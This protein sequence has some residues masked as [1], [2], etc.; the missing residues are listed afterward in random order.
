MLYRR[1]FFMSIVLIMSS[2]FSA[3]ASDKLS[4]ANSPLRDPTTPLMA[5]GQLPSAD[6][7]HFPVDIKVQGLFI[8]KSKRVALINDHFYLIGEQT[9]AGRV[10]AIFKDS[11]VLAQ[12]K[13]MFVIHLTKKV[14]Q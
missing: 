14:R 3:L 12:G 1:Y 13:E 9:P 2:S 7:K 8:S 6:Q 4:S 11:V 10:A 5:Y